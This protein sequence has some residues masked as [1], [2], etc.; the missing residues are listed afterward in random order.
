MSG[1]L[2]MWDRGGQEGEITKGHTNFW[3]DDYV[4]YLDCGD[5]YVYSYVK[6]VKNKYFNYSS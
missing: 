4:L 1:C 5:V 3:G 2:E 6:S